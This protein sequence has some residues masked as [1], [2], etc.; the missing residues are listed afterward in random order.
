MK[1]WSRLTAICLVAASVMAHAQQNYNAVR[2]SRT[3]MQRDSIRA[4]IEQSLKVRST[5]ATFPGLDHL[6]ISAAPAGG[7]SFELQGMDWDALRQVLQFRMRSQGSASVPFLVWT[8]C[9]L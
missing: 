6:D 8:R 5:G 1:R 2:A 7:H 9:N 3:L 4:A